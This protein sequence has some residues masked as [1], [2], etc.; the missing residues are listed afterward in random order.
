MYSGMRK[1]ILRIQDTEISEEV[2][3]YKKMLNLKEFHFPI[4]SLILKSVSNVLS[5]RLQNS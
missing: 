2:S 1:C 4:V 5:P 3:I